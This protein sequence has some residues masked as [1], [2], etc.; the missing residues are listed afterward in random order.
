MRKKV[1][2]KSKVADQDTV[3][4][5]LIQIRAQLTE[6]FIGREEAI[7][8]MLLAH[9]CRENYLFV[10]PPGTAKTA[11]ARCFAKHVTGEKFFAALLGAFTTPEELFGPLSV[12]AFSKGKYETV[13]DDKLADCKL[14]FLDEIF[15][16]GDGCLNQLLTVLNEREYQGKRI[17]LTCCGSATNWPELED[18]TEKTEALYDRLL[19]RCAVEPLET[20][21]QAVA[22]LMASDEATD[23]SPIVFVDAN[24][25]DAAAEEVASVEI[26]LPLM[27]LLCSTR[28]RLATRTVGQ[29]PRVVPGIYISDRRLCAMQSV[30]RA[31]AWLQG[32]NVVTMDDFFQLRF[33]FWV[34]RGDIEVV[35]SVLNS[36]DAIAVKAVL[37]KVDTASSSAALASDSHSG[38]ATLNNAMQEIESI[39]KWV[40]E[41]M[42]KPIYTA[43]GKIQVRM[44]MATLKSQYR[45]L[46]KIA[47]DV[48]NPALVVPAAEGGAS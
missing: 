29:P 20:E 17:P 13:I 48:S 9:L 24:E 28:V 36:L 26:P 7:D 6:T 4:D 34:D 18:R 37:D 33:V 15:K 16:C 46:S 30:L 19:L 41:E 47:E 11:L 8:C 45:Q 42:T 2:I 31:Q 38:I 22:M 35:E 12:D 14:A 10:G 21:D 3:R 44:S 27:R 39:A 5:R 1:R 25:L 23:Y 43:R 32:R 40:K